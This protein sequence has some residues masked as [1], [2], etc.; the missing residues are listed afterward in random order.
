MLENGVI[1]ER[2]T[3]EKLVAAGGVYTKL[4]ETQFSEAKPNP[5]EPFEYT[6]GE[7]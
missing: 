5:N 4:Y 6:E 2:G 1:A 7:D 3:H